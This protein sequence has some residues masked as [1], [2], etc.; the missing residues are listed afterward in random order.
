MNLTEAIMARSGDKKDV[1]PGDIINAGVD[2]AMSHD[3]AG[4][5]S[6]IF[7]TIGVP[8]VWDSEKIVILLDHRVPSNSIK[9]AQGHKSVREFVKEFNI[10]NF[11]DMKEGICHQIMPE[12][13]H[14]MPGTLIVG[15]DSHTTSYGALGAFSTGIGATEMAAVWATGE[16]WLKVPEVFRFD[17]TGQLPKGVYSKDLILRIVGDMTADGAT[18]KGCEYYGDTIEDLSVSERIPITNMSME[19]GA[20][21]AII[22]YDA[23]T[24][25]Y[26]K[27]MGFDVARARKS[28][29]AVAQTGDQNY[30]KE[31]FYDAGDLVPQVACPHAVDN[32]KPI[33]EVAGTPV[34]QALI[35]SCTNGR[36]D[37]LAA[38]ARI[39]KGKTVHP[40]VRL[41]V[42]PASRE[43]YL[44]AVEK[45]LIATFLN[46]KGVILNPGCGPC[47]GAHQGI[48]AEGERCIAT[49]NRNFRGRMGSTESE[50]YLG[51]PAMV[52]ASA[53]AG[54]IVDP[55]EWVP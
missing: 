38:A 41:L 48:M 37:D 15:T 31:F 9:T 19:M 30:E 35:G 2:M 10:L 14:V 47:L 53:V 11:Y 27:E 26:Y 25:G 22:P 5:V 16:L 3:N 46:A 29:A 23:R 50:V 52:A 39:L 40:D 20:K 49:T 4:L 45:G 24:E 51:S 36:I 44:E 17:I 54:E 55:R 28:A 12:K 1:A 21:S 7:R 32:V 8:K 42:I 6:K 18:Y 13:G 34:N 33:D 43:V